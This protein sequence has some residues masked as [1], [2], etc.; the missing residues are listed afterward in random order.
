MYARAEVDVIGAAEV[1][2]MDVVVAYGAAVVV[3]VVGSALLVIGSAVV[4]VVV[5]LVTVVPAA[6]QLVP[7]FLLVGTDIPTFLRCTVPV[8]KSMVS[9]LIS[10]TPSPLLDENN[11]R[12]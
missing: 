9:C 11:K 2:V 1:V 3:G 12:P 8:S 6:K 7:S 5:V 10:Y 4:V